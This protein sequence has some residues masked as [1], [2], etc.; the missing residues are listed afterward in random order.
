MILSMTGYA[1]HEQTIPNGALT[2]EVRSVNH[3]YLELQ[4]KLDDH[5]RVFE[6]NIR[7]LIQA[8]LG[9]GKVDC[10]VFSS[11]T[12][13]LRNLQPSIIKLFNKLRRA[14]RPFRSIFPQSKRWICWRYCA[15]RALHKHLSWIKTL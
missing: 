1:S 12:T 15:C 13:Q 8:K 4:L 14:C 6:N 5:L 11:K 10:R 2:I 7:E 3:R 9:R